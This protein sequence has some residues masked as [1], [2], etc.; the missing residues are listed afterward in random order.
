MTDAT[1]RDVRSSWPVGHRNTFMENQ[2]CVAG[3]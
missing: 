1:L 3:A 2:T